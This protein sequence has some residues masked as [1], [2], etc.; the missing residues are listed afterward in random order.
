MEKMLFNIVVLLFFS[1]SI[2]IGCAP[3]KV[4][5]DQ[6]VNTEE[7]KKI[8]EPSRSYED[9]EKKLEE[10]NSLLEKGLITED[11]YYKTRVRIL[12]EF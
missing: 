6:N 7:T 5:K 8:T 3:T 2:V 9:M 1:A 12:D 10:L 11:E 4:Q